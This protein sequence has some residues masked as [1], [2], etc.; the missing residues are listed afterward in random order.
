MQVLRLVVVLVT[1]LLAARDVR[2]STAD[3]GPPE[4]AQQLEQEF[5]ALE[6]AGPANSAAPQSVGLAVWRRRLGEHGAQC[7]WELRFKEH[8]TRVQHVERE[9]EHARELVWREWR[10]GSG[11]TLHA[12]RAAG[13]SVLS[14][15]EWGRAQGL[16]MQL[17]GPGAVAFPLEVLE[18]LRRGEWNAGELAVFDPLSRSI[19]AWR[20]ETTTTAPTV[21]DQTRGV[22]PL[23][24][25]ELRRVDG[26][27]AG[28]Y[29][30]RGTELTSFRWQNGAL[31][32]RRISADEHARAASELV[33]VASIDATTR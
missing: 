15:V 19:E 27:S 20:V 22:A 25:V 29:D 6:L 24:H 30:F 11:R 12:D 28:S 5:F 18:R 32:A 13:S 16:R 17:E 14:I 3:H 31:T 4:P 26:T 9:L 33:Q 1:A 21:D 8:D 10:P 7:E 2:E 23:R